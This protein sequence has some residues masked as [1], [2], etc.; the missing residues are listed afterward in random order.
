MAIVSSGFVTES[1]VSEEV[2]KASRKLGED[3]VQVRYNLG[4]DWT[5]DPSIYFRIVLTDAS[6]KEEVVG[7]VADRVR[8][9][10]SEELR[11]RE[12]WGLNSYFNFCSKSDHAM[13]NDPK[14][15]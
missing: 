9:I 8:T 6:S 14:W 10:L 11:I 3:V 1:Q 12:N 7:E 2:A 4:S 5:G 13:S 15:A